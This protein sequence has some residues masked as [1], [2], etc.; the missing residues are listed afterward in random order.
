MT[1]STTVLNTLDQEQVT[2]SPRERGEC[3]G[4]SDPL[5]EEYWRTRDPRLREPILKQ[6]ENLINS[7]AV[8]FAHGGVAMDD[9]A[10]VAAIGLIHALERFDN[11]RGVK[12]VTYAVSTMVGEIKHYFRDH[13]WGMKVPR[14]LQELATNLPRV[15]EELYCRLRR[16]PTIAELAERF[17]VREEDILEAMELAHA[18][19]PQSLDAR[20][21][22]ESGDSTD[23]VQ[24]L[25]GASDDRL[26]AVVE[27]APLMTA[28]ETLDE[29]K[30]RIVK[31][32]YFDEWSQSEVGRELGI[33]QMHVSRLE[34]QALTELRAAM[35]GECAVLVWRGPSAE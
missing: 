5:L 31:L 15:E 29:R 25:M 26:E 28:L 6:H 7:L 30:R 8:R 24:D 14:H 20:I 34:R 3:S 27:H 1:R 9:L 22:F 33:S 11:E 13:T 17:R 19:H 10:Q 12:F 4:G 2:P 16:S 21:E 23:R 18:Y 35:G 32:R